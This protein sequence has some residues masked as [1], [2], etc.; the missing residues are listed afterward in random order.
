MKNIF[1]IPILIIS[2]ALFSAV[3]CA[4]N[5]AGEWQILTN[6]NY[7]SQIRRHPH[8]LL[9]VTVPWCGES[10][11][12]M[13]EVSRL[14][15]DKS[16]DFDSLKLMY[17]HRNTEKMLADSIGASDQITVFYYDQSVSYKYRGKLR[18]RSILNSIHPYMSAASPEELPLNTLN[19]QEDLKSFLESTDKALILAEFCGWAPKLVAKVKNN[20]TGTDLTPKEM[21][22]GM[23]K[24]GVENGIAGIPWITEFSMVNDSV[25]S[26]ES[27]YLKFGL[28]LSCTLKEY[29]QFDSFFS[30]LIDVRREF[31]VP[32]E[33]LRFG[34]ISHRSLMSLLDVEDSGTWVA[35]MYFKGCPGCSKVIKDEDDLKNALMT[36]N[37]V[38]RELQFDG[39]DLPLSLPANKASVILFVDRSSETSETRRKSREALDAFREVALHYQISDWMSS[40]NTNH[41]EKSSLLAYKGTSGHPRLQ[42]S[43]TAQKIRLKDKVSFMIINEGKHVTLDKIASDLQGKSLQETLAYLLER[44]K[45]TKLSSLAKELG[46]RLLS[47]DVDIKT[48][49]E[50]PSETDGQSNDASPPSSQEFPLISIVDPQSLP[51]ETENALEREEKTKSI[52]VEVGP[53]SP[54]KE[55]EGI[56]PDKSKHFISIE[57]DKLLEGLELV[58]AEAFKA[59]EKNSSEIEKS[60]EQEPQVQEFKGSFLLCDDNYRL[61]ESLTGGSTIPSLVLVDPRSQHHYVHSEDKILSYFSISEFLHE[62]IRGSLVPYQRSVPVLHS[63]R[64]STSPPFVNLDFREMDSIPQ[65]TMHTLSK[66]VFGSNQSNINAAHT[67]SEDIVVLFSSNWCGFCQRMELVVREAYRAIRGY[68]KMFKSASG[69]EQAPFDADNSMN[70]MKLPLI[71]LMDCTLNDCSLILKSANQ[72]EVYPALMLFPA[73]TETVIS[74]TGDIS[75]ANIIKFIAHHGSNSHHLYSEKGILLTRTE[76][77]EN[78]QDSTR[79]AGHEEAQSA[80]DKFHEVILKNQSPKRVAKYNGGKSRS[81]VSVV[82]N[83]ATSEVV[84]GSILTATDK[85]LEVVPFDNSKIVIVKADEENGFQGLI[86]NKPIRWDAL[87][88]L[89]EGLE[90]LKE[91]PLYFGGPVLR[92]GMP[93]VALTRTVNETRRVEV[94]P[95]IYFL[96]QFATVAN[97]EKLKAGNQ[98]IND[99]WFFFGYT[100][101]GWRQMFQE[102]EEG[103]WTVSND[104]KSLDW[105]LN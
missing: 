87:D 92:R 55:D 9:L 63:R 99:Y 25:S 11:S 95:G 90:F 104:D 35:V 58:M 74:Y 21:E 78:N 16:T 61:L 5:G 38:V 32:P 79:V 96:D 26:R 15:S 1:S 14:V 69:K 68:M 29:K 4:S 54:Y 43:E 51:M 83:K 97:I 60:G 77:G 22:S 30:K 24:C 73:E 8:T 81:Y 102:I 84:V 46:F 33:R 56:S 17:I 75:V 65:V 41:Q 23:L 52:G 2:L 13:R 103:G 40:Q 72:R 36:D 48:A 50:V 105:P 39:Q 100:G 86:F 7:S 45:E 71:Y 70:N 3:D 28:G 80:K 93:L 59:K 18:A 10:R 20:G 27:D 53:S 62:Y 31:L 91:A 44:E 37:S 57:A 67:R 47:D 19:S 101:W 88:Q 12:L 66:L 89:E 85:L 6:L 49:Q 42:L 82:S 76:G 64:E 94:S 98:S 34:L